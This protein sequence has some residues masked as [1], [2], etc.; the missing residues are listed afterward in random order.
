MVLPRQPCLAR[1]LLA[2]AVA[3]ALPARAR[4]DEDLNRQLHQAAGRADLAAVEAAVAAGAEVDAVS[5]ESPRW[6]PLC[7][8]LERHEAGYQHVVRALL[9]KGASASFRDMQGRTPLLLAAQHGHHS[10]VKELLA[11]GAGAV[12]V[13][14]LDGG[15]ALLLAAKRG[16]AEAA[17]LLI[18]GRA[19]VNRPDLDGNTPLKQA[20]AGG[21]AMME[22]F[23]IADRI[24]GKRDP[25]PA[26]S[27]ADARNEGGREEL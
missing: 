16:D 6:T 2:A 26:S 18:E 9:A 19:D 25:A 24:F 8:A 15:T 14:S 17:R 4:G 11:A 27:E 5:S 3:A 23:G 12:D 1:A 21:V 7:Q 10:M 20:M 13:H 22:A